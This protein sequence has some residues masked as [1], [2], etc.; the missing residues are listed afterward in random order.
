MI[1]NSRAKHSWCSLLVS[2]VMIVLVVLTRLS[3]APVKAAISGVQQTPA[4]TQVTDG[5]SVIVQWQQTQACT[6][7]QVWYWVDDP[8][9]THNLFAS[10]TRSGAGPYTWTATIPAQSTEQTVEY[11]VQNWGNCTE[12]YDANTGRFY[13]YGVNANATQT[14]H[15]I[16]VNGDGADWRGNEILGSASGVQVAFTWD[17]DYLYIWF[18]GGNANSDRYNVF[19]DVNPTSNEGATAT[20]ASAQFPANAAPEFAIQWRGDT[21]DFWF[22]AGDGSGWTG[23]QQASSWNGSLYGDDSGQSPGAVELRIQRSAVGLADTGDPFAVFLTISNNSDQLWSA[24][25]S[26]NP[27]TTPSQL[28]TARYWYASKA[29][30]APDEDSF[31]APF[32]GVKLLDANDSWVAYNHARATAWA[33]D[34][35]WALHLDGSGDGNPDALVLRSSTDGAS[36]SS[37]TTIYRPN[38]NTQQDLSNFNLWVEDNLLHATVVDFE[39]DRLIYVRVDISD[40]N[41]PAPGAARVVK[42]FGSDVLE[43]GN[44][45]ALTRGQGRTLWVASSH[46]NGA[47][48]DARFFYSTNGGVNWTQTGT[49]APTMSDTNL[50]ILVPLDQGRIMAIGSQS[51]ATFHY[52]IWNGLDDWSDWAVIS[53][54]ANTGIA[55]Y[56]H[57]ASA[58][59]DAAGNVTFV[60]AAETGAGTG[61]PDTLRVFRYTNAP[62]VW[63]PVADLTVSDSNTALDMPTVH[64]SA[65]GDL[66]VAYKQ[67]NGSA[68]AYYWAKSEDNG[69]TWDPARKVGY[70]QT[71]LLYW[72]STNY[73]SD[74]FVGLLLQD[75]S[76]GTPVDN[77]MFA[78]LDVLTAPNTPEPLAPFDHALISNATPEITF[79][80]QDPGADNVR[81]QIQIGEDTAFSSPTIDDLSSP[82][83]GAFY[84][85]V[86]G[87]S[88]DPFASGH[89]I[90]YTP[91]V[92]LAEGETYYWRIRARD[93]EG[94]DTW[95]G[96]TT[97]RAFTIDSAANVPAWFQ[98][99]AGQFAQNRRE[100]AAVAGDQ[101]VT[102]KTAT[103]T[104]SNGSNDAYDDSSTYDYL[105]TALQLG[106]DATNGSAVTG[107][108]FPR[109][110]FHKE[111]YLDWVEDAYL[112][113]TNQ[114]A[115]SGTPATL[116]IYADARHD[117]PDFAS[118]DRK[119][120]TRTP[121]SAHVAWILNDPWQLEGA[122]IR[123]PN[124]RDVVQEIASLENWDGDA[125][126]NPLALLIANDTGS[127]GRAMT[128]FEGD[129]DS[130]AQLVVTAQDNLSIGIL[131]SP[132]IVFADTFGTGS[133]G[134]VFWTAE[135]PHASA[136][137][138]QIYYEDENGQVQM[139]PI[140]DLPGN[141]SNG[142]RGFF[143]GNTFKQTHFVD[144]SGLDPSAYPVLIL[145]ATL[146]WGNN[147][148]GT[149][150]PTFLEWGLTGDDGTA[151]DTGVSRSIS[152]EPNATYNFGLTGLAARFDDPPE[153]PCTMTV[154]VYRHQEFG[155][156]DATID[157]YWDVT[158]DCTPGAY[159]AI[160]NLSYTQDE[161]AGCTS[162]CPAEDALLYKHWNGTGWDIQDG[163]V[164]VALAHHPEA[165]VA[166]VTNVKQF[167]PI[168]LGGGA[169]TAATLTQFTA[170]P[171][172]EGVLIRWET[173]QEI[174]TLGFNLYRN[175][176]SD[177]ALVRLNDAPIP[178]QAPGMAFG[179]AYTWE[180]AGVMPG[181][182]Y[183]YWLDVLDAG[184][185]VARHGP[186]V[187]ETGGPAA[188]VFC[189]LNVQRP[190][191]IIPL[192]GI[193][194]I[195]IYILH[196]KP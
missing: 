143:P 3:P 140:A 109:V 124:L 191:F 86:A 121:T 28:T 158:T 54:N 167:S 189:A 39:S 188:T 174:A 119:P 53:P 66:Y 164:G 179:A 126:P 30:M 67:T 147:P 45:V 114:S 8:E 144:L 40:P 181:Q 97:P 6:G 43:A 105:T 36:W 194:A 110:T 157:R 64:I 128:A 27:Q 134:Q 78:L 16:H 13:G 138:L 51:D 21:N 46:R 23:G 87:T 150:A 103:F 9:H 170:Q 17:A 151:S 61:T 94:S 162:G 72:G 125:N 196:R 175:T 115:Q 37:P 93:P 117:A 123:S 180:D 58:V 10:A 47:A 185:S 5:E 169:P 32:G 102:A 108:R 76:S 63:Q 49:S 172:H 168:T 173:A 2:A 90:R 116:D 33:N 85:T 133:W 165:N 131:E 42:S 155:G 192:L 122:V 81:Y 19:I 25:P 12:E 44:T 62:G 107:V 118:E 56:L 142:G 7:G 73:T 148:A 120:S 171:Y 101:V 74:R 26:T 68:G 15:T 98:T 129:A 95:S 55:G 71:D 11:Q 1:E 89:I 91:Q 34:R 52:S 41:T 184:G 22:A 69:A 20:F 127:E 182:T 84:D 113:I 60:W 70:S 92:A 161:Y 176:Q 57:A 38:T 18:E 29:T 145:R 183:T 187:V 149:H 156:D 77:P 75:T 137:Y 160:L 50:A 79:G 24:F 106:H 141:N 83:N 111:P 166:T 193:F 65:N 153:T 146:S 112:Q 195:A 159:E 99:A 88:V 82:T 190:A 4:A 152:T 104:L 154:H 178:P 59:A 186:I 96:W 130:A 100:S 136:V 14:F 163:D 31:D 135:T 48:E 177:A 132:P 80:T 139:A 35:W